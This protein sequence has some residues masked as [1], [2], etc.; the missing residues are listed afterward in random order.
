MDQE[1]ERIQDDLRGLLEGE[2]H[3][4]DAFVQMYASDASVYDFDLGNGRVISNASEQA[5]CYARRSSC[6]FCYFFRTV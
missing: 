4:D 5:S 2:V 1:R 6:S 3:C